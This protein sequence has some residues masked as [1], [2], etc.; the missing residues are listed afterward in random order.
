MTPNTAPDKASNARALRTKRLLEGPIAPTL[1]GLA[2]ANLPLMIGQAG[3][4]VIEG[5]YIGQLGVGALASVALVY[6]ILIM[7]Q[8]CAAG[9]MGGAVNSAVA[10][11]LG[12]G[13]PDR[14]ANLVIHACLIALGGA[15]LFMIPMLAFGREVV[16]FFG[17]TDATRDEAVAYASIVFLGAPTVWLANTLASVVRGSGAM[18]ISAAAIFGAFAIQMG[19]GSA[20]TLGLGPF[21]TTWASGRCV[22]TSVRLC[23]RHA[24]PWLLCGVWSGRSSDRFRA[25]SAFHQPVCRHFAGW[26]VRAGLTAGE[27]R[28]G[29]ADHRDCCP[30]RR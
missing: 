24:V 15:L 22:W 4:G 23:R 30:L 9:A 7:M 5:W 11:A 2:T 8:M 14:A 28:H 25:H 21:P 17:A 1:L 29:D 12:A 3:A 20:L 10:R 6:P 13:A 27:C 19:L 18:A 26:T 16:D